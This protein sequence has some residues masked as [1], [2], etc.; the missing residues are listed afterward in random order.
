MPS[1]LRSIQP[2]LAPEVNK[3]EGVTEKRAV[4]ITSNT[5]RTG[6]TSSGE[7]H[8][9]NPPNAARNYNNSSIPPVSVVVQPS[10]SYLLETIDRPAV[11]KSVSTDSTL[12]AV[13]SPSNSSSGLDYY[14]ET[15]EAA[16][17]TT[18][19]ADNG[20]GA[21]VPQES[22]SVKDNSSSNPRRSGKNRRSNSDIPQ[23][24]R[25]GFFDSYNSYIG[26]SSPT[27]GTYGTTTPP[28]PIYPY[29]Y[30]QQGSPYSL[31]FVQQ[32]QQQ[33]YPHQPPQ[34]A[35][36]S[37]QPQQF[38]Y[39]Q[40]Q[41]P[42]QYQFPPQTQQQL[43]PH[44]RP[45]YQHRHASQQQY[46]PR[47][48][49]PQLQQQQPNL[50]TSSMGPPPKPKRERSMSHDFGEKKP[51]LALP[52][53][54]K[55]ERRPDVSGR[56]SS[57][58]R[59]HRPH[60]KSRSSSAAMPGGYGA[61]W[62]TPTQQE[63]DDIIMSQE[64]DSQQQQSSGPQKF[65]PR[66]EFRKL[67]QGISPTGSQ[68]RKKASASFSSRG[69]V[70]WSPQSTPPTYYGNSSGG[71]VDP[72]LAQY[73]PAQYSPLLGGVQHQR[74]QGD[75]SSGRNIKTESLRKMHVRQ[76]SAQLFMA[77][78]KGVEQP[79]ACRNVF[80][81]LL[82]VFHLLVLAYLG[83]IY[84]KD[85]LKYHGDNPDQVTIIYSSLVYIACWSG[86]FAVLISALLLGAMT[87]FARHFVQI[88]L[89]VVIALSFIWGTI[90]IG[91]S[92]QTV[93][94]VTGVIALALAVAYT[95]IVWDR[96]PFA[97]ANLVTALS[98]IRA[99]PGIVAVAFAFQ[100]VTLVWSIGFSIVVFGVYDAIRE[101][102]KLE[103]SQRMTYVIY[104]L[105][106]MSFIWTF[107]VLQVRCCFN[108]VNGP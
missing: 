88:A 65:S 50:P 70:S 82:F 49:Q 44:Q 2:V 89:F 94:P 24:V 99:F 1:K 57:L 93:V 31:P 75:H 52:L 41:Q 80:F 53:P 58:H 68:G 105:L 97:A 39:P 61:F 108:I 84:G 107:H 42:Q 79:L 100:A 26:S 9:S 6:S 23:S 76:H 96:I 22:Q 15:M 35:Y 38:Q 14:P 34:L 103:P 59:E 67:A 21:H 60:R 8:G 85:A 3:P 62:N 73:S 48:H 81:L 56:R 4:S 19:A 29:P 11:K 91:V 101:P 95:F 37:Q 27:A 54:S 33:P 18:A 86:L 55:S 28:P 20:V 25:G 74:A 78:I 51:L 102:G 36:R 7:S 72:R 46:S 40:Q 32:P 71:S 104:G 47:M 16:A 92:P 64:Q 45:Q 69:G 87:Y 43:P 30:G 106:A 10:P 66:A 63:L 17:A 5:S 98:G 83:Q 77:D 12:S 90:G 13:V